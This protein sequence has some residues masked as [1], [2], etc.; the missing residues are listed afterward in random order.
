M[1]VEGI[2]YSLVLS[3]NLYVKKFLI[4]SSGCTDDSTILLSSLPSRYIFIINLDEYHP[5]LMLNILPALCTHKSL[6]YHVGRAQ[7]SEPTVWNMYPQ[8][9][10][11]VSTNRMGARP[12]QQHT[13]GFG[14]EWT[15]SSTVLQW[16]SVTLVM[17]A[18]LWIYNFGLVDH[19]FVPPSS[20]IISSAVIIEILSPLSLFF[21][22][23]A[24]HHPMELSIVLSGFV[25]SNVM[26]QSK[27]ETLALDK[28]ES[29]V[30]EDHAAGVHYA[31]NL[32]P[33]V[34]SGKA[35]SK[36]PNDLCGSCHLDESLFASA[37]EPPGT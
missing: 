32:L 37:Y 26:S 21:Y 25:S 36:P 22:V 34:V 12:P 8:Y 29:T 14:L 11:S 1:T 28:V 5:D 10:A 13:V 18:L 23:L 16:I 20:I 33:F 19:A 6:T 30:L 24:R 7:G 27:T 35:I 17:L 15:S 31:H 3:S 2:H 9:T 4:S